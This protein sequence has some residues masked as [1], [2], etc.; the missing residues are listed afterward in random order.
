MSDS[1][2]SLKELAEKLGLEFS[3]NA[4][5]KITH[6]CGLDSLHNG[7]LA[8]LTS[9]DGLTSVPVPAGMSRH[10]DISVDEIISS[11]VALIVSPGVKHDDHNLI[12]SDDPLVAH[13]EAAKLL[14]SVTPAIPG[15]SGKT[16]VHSSCLLYTSPS[17]RDATLSRMPSSA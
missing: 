8:Y 4:K 5:L 11:Q 2:L 16:G 6:V 3:G 1:S 17:P 7:G 10:A 13:V 14:H 12:F 9:P 15:L